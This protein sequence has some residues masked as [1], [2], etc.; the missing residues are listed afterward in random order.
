[1]HDESWL[2][3][4][5]LGHVNMNFITQL[6]NNELVRGLPKISFEK[7]KVC[8]TCLIGKQIIFFLKTKISSL[9]QDLLSFFTWIC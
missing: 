7:N 3:H 8:E 4:K 1:M 6:N 5:R 2:W 9:H